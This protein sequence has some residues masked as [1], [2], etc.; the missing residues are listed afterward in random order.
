MVKKK[1]AP[2]VETTDAAQDMNPTT[3]IEPANA[4]KKRKAKTPPADATTE[5]PVEPEPEAKP[6][7]KKGKRAK[8]DMTLQ[9]VFAGY[10]E[11]LEEEGKTGG[12]IASYKSELVLAGDGLGLDT[13]IADLTP[14]KVLL[15]FTCDR[16]VKK[17]NKKPKSPL[18]IDKTRRV[19]RQALQWAA[20]KKIIAHAPVPEMAASH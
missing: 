1:D 16:V 17:Q 19:V 6:A 10:V 13:R 15:F 8:S 18:S 7:P 9:D 4:P 20:T 12:T 14:D 2:P 11:S 3:T 5:P